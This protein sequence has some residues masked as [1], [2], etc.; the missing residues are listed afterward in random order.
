MRNDERVIGEV[1]KTQ[2][3]KI[4]VSVKT[5]KG[6]RYADLR[7]FYLPRE[8]DAKW[9]P[10]TQGITLRPDLVDDLKGLVDKLAQAVKQEAEE[11]GEGDTLP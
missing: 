5:Y 9:L 3:E 2:A 8:P 4:C 6:W 1:Q 10:T 7:Q 11:E